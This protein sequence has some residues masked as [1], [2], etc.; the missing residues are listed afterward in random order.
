MSKSEL[1]YAGLSNILMWSSFICDMYLKAL[2]L[3]NANMLLCSFF[4]YSSLK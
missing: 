3:P 2:K 1:E 4:K